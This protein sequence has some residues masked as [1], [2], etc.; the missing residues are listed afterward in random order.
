MVKRRKPI[1]TDIASQVLLA[2]R[3]ACCVCQKPQVQVHH[4][5][6]N[7]ANNETENL[8]VLCLQ[9][10]DHAS[11]QLGLSRKL[12]PQEIRHY[13]AQW[14]AKCAADIEALARDRLRFYAT[15]YKNP[16]RIRE[17]FGALSQHR[18]L[19]AVA[20][21]EQQIQEDIEHHKQDGG[22]QWQA[23][24]R[25]NDLTRHLIYS[26][27]AG[28]LWPAVLPRVTGHRDDPDYPVDLGPPHGMI[29][30]H[31]FDLYCQLMVRTLAII[32]P[33]QPIEY[34]WSL[35]DPELIDHFAGSLVSF[36]ERSIGKDIDGLRGAD[37]R[38]LGRVQ[39]RVQRSGRIY[40]A[41][42]DIKN[43]YVFSDTGAL[44]LERSKVAGL[45]VL[46]DASRK[47]VGGKYELHV[48]LKPLIIGIGGLGQSVDGL[49]DLG[50]RASGSKVAL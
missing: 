43:M 18:R 30:F 3:H 20:S 9:H 4:I 45:A 47:K 8:S 35:R 14:E 7:P 25:N 10:H 5:D 2:N 22:F 31:G 49:W 38:P 24:P 1:P 6:E 12:R 28:D 13:K 40:R 32:N 21:L 41:F 46:E 36:R 42:M 29:A 19:Q 11:M 39:F 37:K 27:K 15:V 48:S 23:L 26:L 16:P 17:L 34:L 50:G 44:N 33:P